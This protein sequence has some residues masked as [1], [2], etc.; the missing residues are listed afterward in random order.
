MYKTTR[1]AWE[2]DPAAVHRYLDKYD[3]LTNVPTDN[4]EWKWESGVVNRFFDDLVV[5]G[6]T[7][8][9]KVLLN[10]IQQ[11]DLEDLLEYEP[12]LLAGQQAQAYDLTLDEA[13][14]VARHQMRDKARLECRF[15][16]SSPIIRNFSMKLDFND[17]SW[18][19]ILVPVY[20]AIYRY[21]GQRF[22]VMVNGQTGAISGQRPVDWIKVW[23]GIIG[24]MIPALLVTLLGLAYRQ[25]GDSFSIFVLAFI[26]ALV[27]IGVS[28][29]FIRRAQALDD[30]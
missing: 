20:I 6:T 3:I 21:R 16:G 23:F 28:T 15:Q 22:Q 17:E 10:R 4:K 26:M 13:W 7:R 9:S 5:S 18:R 27:A 29:E 1:E 12:K 24:T 8:L 19:Y 14:Q 11:Y 30:F 2:R 25:I